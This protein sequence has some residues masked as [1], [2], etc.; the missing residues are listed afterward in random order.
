[1][2]GSTTTVDE[3]TALRWMRGVSALGAA[4]GSGG[5]VRHLG[6]SVVTD[7][8]IDRSGIHPV[9]RVLHRIGGV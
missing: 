1:M 5:V 2:F 7:V 6:T 9:R 4:R 8:R 3:R